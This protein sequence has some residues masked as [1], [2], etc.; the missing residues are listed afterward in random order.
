[1]YIFYPSGALQLQLIQLSLKFL[2]FL[3]S[4]LAIPLSRLAI[5]SRLTI[6]LSR[7]AFLRHGLKLSSQSTFSLL[8]VKQGGNCSLGGGGNDLQ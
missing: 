6:P 8:A 3:L 2:A 7:L 1:M 5:T 4:C